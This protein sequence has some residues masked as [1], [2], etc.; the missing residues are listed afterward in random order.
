M[1]GMRS[2]LYDGAGSLGRTSA[3]GARHRRDAA[4]GRS[5]GAYRRASRRGVR[6]ALSPYTPVV[7]A[8]DDAL[9]TPAWGASVV[10]LARRCADLSGAGRRAAARDAAPQRRQRG[11]ATRVSGR[12]RGCP[13]SGID[14]GT[15]QRGC[16]TGGERGET[17][18]RQRPFKLRS[19]TRWPTIRCSRRST[20]AGGWKRGGGR[21]PK[22][23]STAEARPA[24]AR[25][26]PA[27]SPSAGGR[28]PP[29]AQFA[30]SPL[31]TIM[32]RG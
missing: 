31:K 10:Q 26:S 18:T 17:R 9:A 7:A 30:G 23:F 15:A 20:A 29:R 12:G 3:G 22:K 19:A 27:D 32:L 28:E 1:P 25:H 13:F 16:S 5:P 11:E 2:R 21:E 4:H 6:P 24:K 8:V 14:A